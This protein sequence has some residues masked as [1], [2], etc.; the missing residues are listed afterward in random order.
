[1]H[2]S[3]EIQYETNECKI[4]KAPN[5]IIINNFYEDLQIDTI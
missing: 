5:V 1:M 3:L 2:D 4:K